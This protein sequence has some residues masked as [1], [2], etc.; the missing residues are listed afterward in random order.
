MTLDALLDTQYL[1]ELSYLPDKLFLK[2]LIVFE[3]VSTLTTVSAYHIKLL[4]E[5]LVDRCKLICK[6]T[7]DVGTFTEGFL[8]STSLVVSAAIQTMVDL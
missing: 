4:A 7:L 1:A 5:L 8:S 2:S 3:R 6:L